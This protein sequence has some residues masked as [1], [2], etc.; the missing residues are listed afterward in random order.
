MKTNQIENPAASVVPDVNSASDKKAQVAQMF[1]SIAGKYD[2]LNHFLSLGIDRIWRKIAIKSA[3]EFQPR[4]ILDVATGTGDMAIAAAK[5]SPDLK[6]TG[7]DIAS[8][9]LDEGRKKIAAQGLTDIIKLELG[10][11]ETLPFP[12][13][14]FDAVM[15]AYGV[16]N[17]EDL[18]KGLKQMCRVLKPG[19]RLVVLE[20]SKPTSFPVKQGYQLYFKYILPTLG[21]MF[22]KH[23]TAYSYLP[24]SVNAFPDGEKFCH[25]LTL[26][27]YKQP[28]ARKLTFGVTTL[29]TATK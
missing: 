3:L 20:F 8:Q 24:D 21:K 4:T 13:G 14:S 7:V 22:S 29:Y 28:V 11:S 1:N 15:C 26:C 18:E 2:F 25:I 27:G 10:D 17:F 5:V 23:D 19:G 12:D 9:M 6:V 16:R